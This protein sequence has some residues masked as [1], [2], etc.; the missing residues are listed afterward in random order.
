VKPT[1]YIETTIISYLAARLS[2]DLLVAA[3]Q[4]LTVEWWMDRRFE[5]EVFSSEFVATEIAAGDQTI[6]RKRL[7]F[8]AGIP[9]LP[10]T[11]ASLALAQRLVQRQ[12]I[13]LKFAA[14]ASHVS[15]STVHGID[16]LLTWNCKHIAN[17][18]IQRQLNTI[19]ERRDTN[20]P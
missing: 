17:A 19:V 11:E 9:F 3:H 20:H 18:Q 10:T 8:L 7:D 5:F 15:I 16:Y 12:V 13:P 6:A 14:D 1:V 2:R 4:Q